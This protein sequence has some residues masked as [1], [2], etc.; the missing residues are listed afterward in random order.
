MFTNVT[1]SEK[2]GNTGKGTGKRIVG[3]TRLKD[4]A[5]K[6]ENQDLQDEN[7][8]YVAGSISAAWH[9]SQASAEPYL[10]NTQETN[11][12]AVVGICLRTLTKARN[13]ENTE[14]NGKRRGRRTRLKDGRWKQT[15]Q[16]TFQQRGKSHN[17]QLNTTRR[18]QKLTGQ[19]AA[20][21]PKGPRN[22]ISR[23]T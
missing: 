7:K 1:E 20:A 19:E 8:T 15:L 12:I 10:S 11:K 14:R 13:K 22:H 17:H 18:Q 16:E 2:R 23:D 4:G 5:E 6:W 21:T 3:R 9:D